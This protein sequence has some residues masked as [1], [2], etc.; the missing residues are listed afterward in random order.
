TLALRILATIGPLIRLA[1]VVGLFWAFRSA[2][3][4]PWAVVYQR[5]A[6]GM[7]LAFAMLVP[8]SL[9]AVN[10]AYQT[11]SPSDIGWM[12][13]FWFAASAASIA[14]AS[15]PEQRRAIAGPRP[16]DHAAL[17]CAA[18]VAVP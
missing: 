2:K 18:V 1:A 3:C 7:G 13:P 4:G 10:G 5:L 6:I 16:R 12:L 11:G 9:T 14:P 17:L 15:V 8:L